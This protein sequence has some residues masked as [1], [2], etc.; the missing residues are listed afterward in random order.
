MNYKY[1]LYTLFF[2][3]LIAVVIFVIS[4]LYKNENLINTQKTVEPTEKEIASQLGEI[5]MHFQKNDGQVDQVVDYFVRNGSTSIFFTP[6]EVVYSM[7]KFTSQNNEDL[8]EEEDKIDENTS[9][10]Q[11][12]VRQS[13]LGAKKQVEI[14]GENELEAKVNYFIGNDPDKWVQNGR[15]F[16]KVRYQSVYDGIDLVYSGLAS[17]LM[18]E[19]I[20]DPKA[21]PSQI[22]VNLE[23]QDR[24]VLNPDGV[25]VIQTAISNIALQAHETYQTIHGQKVLVDS[26]YRLI[27]DST[28]TFELGEYDPQYPLFIA[29]K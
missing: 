6:A 28:Y 19:Y 2:S 25:L 16:G 24:I 26:R 14:L 7:T 27:D 11:V 1:I 5:Q 12:V 10:K 3:I 15:T 18:Y 13:F 29:S 8:D 23:G 22:K 4:S 20:V 21:D 9:S 17:E